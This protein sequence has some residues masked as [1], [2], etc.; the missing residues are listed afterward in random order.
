MYLVTAATEME[1]AFFVNAMGSNEYVSTLVTGVGPVET[2]V[3]LSSW[4]G[5]YC[6]TISAVIN[7]GVAGAYSDDIHENSTKVL[8]ICLAEREILGDLGIAF[9]DRIEPFSDSSLA[10]TDTFVLDSALLGFACRALL[11]EKVEFHCG[12]FITVSSVS[13]TAQRGA[14]VGKAYK[15]LCENMEGAAVA[16][17]CMEFSLPCLEIRSI[18]NIVQ[19]RDTKSWKL[20]EAG[21]RAGLATALIMKHLVSGHD[22]LSLSNSAIQ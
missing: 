9:D 14:M 20:K 8:D 5:K 18:S 1:M 4:L 3:R 2:A 6:S 16:R 11:K 15:G 21:K 22:G 13:G 12:T 10:V 7:L 17:T 19:D